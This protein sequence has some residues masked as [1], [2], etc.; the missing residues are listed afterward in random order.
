MAQTLSIEALRI[1]RPLR[2]LIVE[3]SEDDVSLLLAELRRGGYDVSWQCVE[4][5]DALA[6]QLAADTWDLVIS[7]HNLPHFSAPAALRIVRERAGDLPFIIVSGSIGEAQ[8]VA[9]MRAGANDYF[10][11]GQLACLTPAVE[12][13][14]AEAQQRRRREEAEHAPDTWRNSCAK[15]KDEAVGRLAEAFLGDFNN[16]LTAILV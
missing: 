14:L 1:P 8:A 16:L 10:V 11:K 3:D 15:H 6:A 5:G 4:T 9:G 7:D 13:E 2:V 12:R